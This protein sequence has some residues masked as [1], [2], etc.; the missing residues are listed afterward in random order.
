MVY[1]FLNED[2]SATKKIAS[3]GADRSPGLPASLLFT[4]D[5]RLR[6]SGAQAERQGLAEPVRLPQSG[7][8]HR[9]LLSLTSDGSLSVA[10]LS[11]YAPFL[12]EMRQPLEEISE[13][14]TIARP[15]L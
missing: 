2:R 5:E 13:E 11:L 7:E 12:P 15:D 3:P 4:V 14:I 9:P 8:A 10:A 1:A 6:P